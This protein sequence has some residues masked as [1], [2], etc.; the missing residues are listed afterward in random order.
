MDKTP[1]ECSIQEWE[2]EERAAAILA[3][4]QLSLRLCRLEE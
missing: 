3:F 4:A 2:G 1:E